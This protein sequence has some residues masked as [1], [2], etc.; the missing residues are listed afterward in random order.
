M[1]RCSARFKFLGQSPFA[2]QNEGGEAELL[3]VVIRQLPIRYTMDEWCQQMVDT[4]SLEK[5]TTFPYGIT[6][7]DPSQS[8]P[9]APR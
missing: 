4:Y 7:L 9:A 1:C 8:V 5:M 3:V 2:K 6:S